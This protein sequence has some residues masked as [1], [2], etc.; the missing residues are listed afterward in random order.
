ML[1][2]PLLL[3]SLLLWVRPADAQPLNPWSEGTVILQNGDTLRGLVRVDL[4]GNRVLLK[5]PPQGE[6]SIPAIHVKYVG[7]EGLRAHHQR[8]G[9]FPKPDRPRLAEQIAARP[10]A[11]YITAPSAQTMLLFEV[12]ET[13]P[14]VVLLY[15]PRAGTTDGPQPDPRAALLRR[16]WFDPPT[17]GF[18][19]GH[20]TTN[21]VVPFRCSL[22]GLL[23]VLPDHHNEVR[24][25]AWEHPT[26]TVGGAVVFYNSLAPNP[27]YER[28]APEARKSR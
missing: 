19:L 13:G 6:C 2:L 26:L 12:L 3:W 5:W 20:L 7:V 24:R 10:T 16:D 18:Y 11:H 15:H 8:F 17:E 22:P 14:R 27:Y 23:N 9:A 1:R 28:P 4:P 21:R 25:F